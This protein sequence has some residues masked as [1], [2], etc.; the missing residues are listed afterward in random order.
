M[1]LPV[2]PVGEVHAV[3]SLDEGARMLLDDFLTSL[4]PAV[5]CTEIKCITRCDSFMTTVSRHN[6]G[7]VLQHAQS[8]T[9]HATQQRQCCRLQIQSA[10]RNG[11]SVK[12]TTVTRTDAYDDT[13][14]C[15]LLHRSRVVYSGQPIEYLWTEPRVV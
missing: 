1:Y 4:K 14:R 12:G 11:G 7:V 13:Q 9:E 10:F 6:T 8:A 5:H 15:T 2:P 3:P